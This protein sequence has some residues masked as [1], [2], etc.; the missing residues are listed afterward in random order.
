MEIEQPV[1]SEIDS[2]TKICSF[3]KNRIAICA[4]KNMQLRLLSKEIKSSVVK[5]IL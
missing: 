3:F 4:Y 5:W 1:F 2:P